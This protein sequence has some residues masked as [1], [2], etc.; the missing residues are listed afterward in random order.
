MDITKKTYEREDVVEKYYER[1]LK[2]PDYFE[3][4]ISKLVKEFPGKK[5]LDV[6]CGP[7]Q[8]SRIFADQGFEVVGID[9]SKAMIDKANSLSVNKDNLEYNVM[10]MRNLKGFFDKSTF[11]VI[12]ASASLLHLDLD[13]IQKV[14]SDFKYILKRGGHIFL[15]VK[16]GEQG[17]IL[18]NDGD[19]GESVRRKF[20]FI[21]ERWFEEL[22]KKLK[23]S[24]IDKKLKKGSVINKQSSYWGNYWLKSD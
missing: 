4:N 6:G 12:W 16:L 18:L 23:L 5:L 19:L 10:D 8:F 24:I 22:L 7:G 1:Y 11:D 3:I 9:Y 15:I 21:N 17:T 20:T 13:E 2:I 14:L